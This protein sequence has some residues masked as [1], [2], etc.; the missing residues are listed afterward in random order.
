[1]TDFVILDRE[2]NHVIEMILAAVPEFPDS[3]EYTALD[4]ELRH[5]PGLVV[6][7]LTRFLERLELQ[8]AREAQDVATKKTLT[9]IYALVERFATSPDPEVVNV[10]ETEM[11]WNLGDEAEPLVLAHLLPKARDLHDAWAARWQNAARLE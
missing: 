6:A 10:I 3:P 11:F 5:L 8:R 7:A 1:M 9:E 2:Y 4:E